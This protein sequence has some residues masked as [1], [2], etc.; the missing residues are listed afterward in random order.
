MK[1]IIFLLTLGC[2]GAIAAAQPAKK[3]VAKFPPELVRFV[4]HDKNPVFTGGGKGKWDE[5]IRE[6]GWILR[7]GDTYKLW[8]TG[9]QGKSGEISKRLGYA[10]SADGIRW[11]RHPRNP[12]YGEHWTED[13]MV[14][15][16]RGKYYMFAEGKLDRAHL[17]VSGNGIDWTR[18]GQ[19][20][21]R[22]KNGKPIKPGPFGTPTAW[23][24][25]GT[26]YLFYEREDRGIWLATSRDLKVWT[27][28]QDE[29]VLSPGPGIYD[30]DLI[31]LNQ[32]IKYKGRYYAY[33]HGTGP[34]K[35]KGRLWCTCVATSTDL[36][37]WEKYPDNPLQ[38][39]AQN[40]SSG[41][42][43]HDGKQ[44]RL[45]TMHPVVNLHFS[46]AVRTSKKDER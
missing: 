46:Q 4:P 34:Q 5:R 12:I 10:T 13:M 14:V 6:R 15:K 18:I 2:S 25:N 31:A 44:F 23:F 17:L 19:L 45:Y 21:I 22:L 1:R 3:I 41:M 43:V 7:E 40:K 37:H 28:V 39:I 32:I 24:E 16:H 36:V 20:D 9:Y 8:Y 26:C 11:T 30:K 29:P 33:Y 27:H 35:G 42:V 38:P